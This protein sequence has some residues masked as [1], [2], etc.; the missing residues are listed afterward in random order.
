MFTNFL[1]CELRETVVFEMMSRRNFRIGRQT[2]E[3]EMR[4]TQT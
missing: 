4:G 2:E 3:L 1:L